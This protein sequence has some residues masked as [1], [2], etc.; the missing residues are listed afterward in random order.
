VDIY[1]KRGGGT[2]T[3]ARLLILASVAALRTHWK[4][5]LGWAALIA[6]LSLVGGSARWAAVILAVYRLVSVGVAIGGRYY[7]GRRARG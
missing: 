6:G 1:D 2:M 3:R 7:V 4:R 5:E